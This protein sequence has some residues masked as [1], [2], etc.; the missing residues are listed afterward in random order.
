[1]PYLG[2]QPSKGLVGTAG[3]DDNA[4]TGAKTKDALIGDYSDVT[5]TAS[6]LIMYG[7]ADDSNNTKRDT[8]QGILDLTSGGNSTLVSH[9]AVSSDV[10]SIAFTGLGTSVAAYE[11]DLVLHPA[12]NSQYLDAVFGTGSTSYVTSGYGWSNLGNRADSSGA[13]GQA[14][15]SASSMHI[16]EVSSTNYL[17]TDTGEG[18]NARCILIPQTGD[19]NYPRLF[20]YGSVLGED[21]TTVIQFTGSGS[22]LSTTAVTAVK[23]AL[24][25]GGNLAGGYVSLRSYSKS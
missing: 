16:G 23:F 19:A 8:V 5:I 20:W 3:I 18:I 14:G 10:A 12:V 13:S 25:G 21:A 7:D 4:V 15:T 17:G 9:V 2:T 24:T 1:M 22:V 6:D 11:F